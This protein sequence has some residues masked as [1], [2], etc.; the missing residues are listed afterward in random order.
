[1]PVLVNFLLRSIWSITL[2]FQSVKLLWQPSCFLSVPS[3]SLQQFKYSCRWCVFNKPVFRY[4]AHMPLFNLQRSLLMFKNSRQSTDAY[5]GQFT[6]LILKRHSWKI[7]GA[8][9][10]RNE[11]FIK[12]TRVSRQVRR[13]LCVRTFVFVCER[14]LEYVDLVFYP[15]CFYFMHEL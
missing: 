2:N 1:M 14:R 6:E 12:G 10:S 11:V 8:L 9:V 3:L 15:T 7:S 5:S 4:R 13:R